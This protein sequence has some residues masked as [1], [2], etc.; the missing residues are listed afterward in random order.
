MRLFVERLVLVYEVEAPK[1]RPLF[2]FEKIF[3]IPLFTLA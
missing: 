2:L 3:D 1:I